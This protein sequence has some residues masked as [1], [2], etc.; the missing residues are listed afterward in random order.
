MG[1]FYV[2]LAYACSERRSGRQSHSAD[3]VSGI[4]AVILLW[5]ALIG[6]EVGRYG[7]RGAAGSENQKPS[8]HLH[9]FKAGK[10]KI[11]EPQHIHLSFLDTS[12]L[13]PTGLS[14]RLLSLVYV[15]G[16]LKSYLGS[17]A[18]I[19]QKEEHGRRARD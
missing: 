8:L 3:S 7:R 11:R 13:Q 17:F 6:H 12:K 4:W 14:K 18:F 19:N 1:L 10:N 5:R 2:G 15:S 16:S 9:C